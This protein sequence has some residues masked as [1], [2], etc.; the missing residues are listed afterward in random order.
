MWVA[1]RLEH[2]KEAHFRCTLSGTYAKFSLTPAQGNTFVELE[3]GM[4][5]TTFRWRMLKTVSRSYFKRW[6]IDVLDALPAR[7]RRRAASP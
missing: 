2:L 4:D 6:V 1:E 5:P 7:C 3:S